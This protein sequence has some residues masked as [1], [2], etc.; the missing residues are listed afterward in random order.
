MEAAMESSWS[1]DRLDELKAQVDA[2]ATRTDRGFVEFRTELLAG[3][4]RMERIVEGRFEL[5]EEK[6]DQRFNQIDERFNQVDERFEEVDR[7][8]EQIDVRLGG[9]EMRLV[10][11]E[12]RLEGLGERGQS[13]E[14]RLDGLTYGIIGFAASMVVAIAALVAVHLG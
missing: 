9:V 4:E 10:K 12:V 2:L 7:R 3:F 13:V 6:L 1:D 8:F 11:V 14:S 5:I